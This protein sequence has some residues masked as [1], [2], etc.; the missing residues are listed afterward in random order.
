MP[1]KKTPDQTPA[2][3][4]RAMLRGLM[5]LLLWVVPIVGI[6]YLIGSFFFSSDANTSSRPEEMLDQYKAFVTPY[7]TV[8]GPRPGIIELDKWLDF[9]DSDSRKFFDENYARIVQKY[10]SGTIDSQVG[11]LKDNVRIEAMR[12]L[13]RTPPPQWAVCHHE[14]NPPSRFTLRRCRVGHILSGVQNRPQTRAKPLAH[15]VARRAGRLHR[16][17]S[18]L[19]VSA[20][21]LPSC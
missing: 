7:A 14:T 8:G 16:Q 13:V 21:A 17:D 20:S 10:N 15:E 3:N 1:P 12:F 2:E 9:F 11:E 19:K 4:L 18:P 6:V 5:R